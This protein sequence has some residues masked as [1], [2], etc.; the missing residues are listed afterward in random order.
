MLVTAGDGTAVFWRHAR[1]RVTPI[2][3]TPFTCRH[4]EGEVSLR[5]AFVAVVP[6]N[7][8]RHHDVA[9]SASHQTIRTASRRSTLDRC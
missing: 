3:E 2:Y 6:R 7:R 4:Q 8:R 5:L 1:V 9:V